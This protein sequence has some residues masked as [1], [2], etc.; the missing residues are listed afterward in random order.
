MG[1]FHSPNI[2]SDGMV[3][4]LDGRNYKSTT[5]NINI[6]GRGNLIKSNVSYTTDYGGGFVF[7]GNN[8]SYIDIDRS[9]LLTSGSTDYSIEAWYL[10][11]GV[12]ATSRSY[13]VI[14]SNYGPGFTGSNQ[15]WFFTAGLWHGGTYGYVGGG[16]GSAYG[17]TE[18]G[19]V[20]HIASTK[21]GSTY[22]TWYQGTQ[23]VNN[24]GGANNIAVTNVNW[25]IGCDV[26]STNAEALT[27]TI[28]LIRMW[29][30]ALSDSEILYNFNSEK[31][32]FG[33]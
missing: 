13:G 15:I 23:Y 6:G 25:R 26:N 30:R 19:V 24:T 21:S 2:T 18:Y 20:R 11:P 9:D 14:I 7:T 22:K 16:P 1:L 4:C 10:N 8:S 29:N 31:Q 33:Y 17:G 32:R 12:S 27:G 5:G 3:F 28:Y